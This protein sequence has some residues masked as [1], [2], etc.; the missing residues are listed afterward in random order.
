MK[1]LIGRSIKD[2]ENIALDYGQ[3][4]YRGDK[5]IIGSTTIGI[6]KKI[7]IK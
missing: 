1:N 5:S 6:R 3:A 7:L 4:A 2:L